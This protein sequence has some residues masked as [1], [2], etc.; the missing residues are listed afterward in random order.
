VRLAACDVTDRK[1]LALLLDSIADAHPLTAV[2]HAAGTLD[3][4]MIGALTAERLDG[5]LAP[6]V[7][8]AWHLHELTETSSLQAFVLLSSAAGVLGG[9]GQGNY[10]AANAFLD[11]LAADRRARGLPGSSIAYGLWEQSS[12]MTESLSK[13]D[14]SRIA[15]SGLGTLSCG[16]GLELFDAA[17]GSEHAL[18]L[19]APLDLRALQA[20][21]RT[22][23]LPVM[24]SGLVRV[25]KRRTD[26]RSESLA[27]RL[28]T[29]PE[30]EREAT[31]VDL[32]HAQVAVVLGHDSPGAIE[33]QRTFKDL[34]FDS[35]AAVEL[36]NR[37]AAMT[38]LRLPAT[39]VF[40]Y[41]TPAELT[42]NLLSRAAA[43]ESGATG[44]A[45]VELNRLERALSSLAL[46]DRERAQIAGRLQVLL[47]DLATGDEGENDHLEL[48]SVDEVFAAMDR[49]LGES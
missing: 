1:A 11:A 21:A 35:L 20:Q 33:P 2:V 48:G 15:S 19:A 12:A 43:G 27:R 16:E 28:S 22:G 49:E 9:L 31:V 18:T 40:D 8:A 30:A 13:A 41:P 17:I 5:V 32:V 24:L 10:A 29:I 44:S 37:L 39:L 46:G 6:K 23:V 47:S 26:E 38:G 3:D 42:G 34:G 36:R 45:V 7:D 4:G 14:R 25:P